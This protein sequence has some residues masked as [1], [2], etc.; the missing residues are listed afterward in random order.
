MKATI[1]ERS[2][3][4]NLQMQESGAEVLRDVFRWSKT[5]GRT[6]AE[7]EGKSGDEAAKRGAEIQRTLRRV[8]VAL[9]SAGL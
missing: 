4:V 3:S 2:P 8:R 9:E 7:K 5:I 1:V 6:I